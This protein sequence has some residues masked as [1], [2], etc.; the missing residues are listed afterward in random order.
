MRSWT[1]DE[2]EAIGDAGEL[3]IAPRCADGTLRPYTTIWVVRDGEGLFVR[4]YHGREGGW[5]RRALAS[6]SG[7]ITA[8]AI[9]RDVDLIEADRALDSRIDEAYRAKYGR[10]P[11]VDPMLSEAAAASTLR[12]TPRA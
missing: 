11:Y 9:E 5:F 1:A 8:G 6:G 4:S 12:L 2:L 10:S 3:R 7:R